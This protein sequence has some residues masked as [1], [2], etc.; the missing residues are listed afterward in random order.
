M[1]QKSI[2]ILAAV[3]IGAFVVNV[4]HAQKSSKMKMTTPIPESITTPAKIESR[5]GTLEF[6][7]GSP[8]QDTADKIYDY[9]DFMHGVEAFLYALP[10][11]SVHAAGRGI[12]SMGGDNQ[13][14]LI[15]EELMNARSLFLT[16][17]T[18]SIY[19]M[20]WLD[21]KD[22]P[23]VLETPPDVLG[24]V[25]DHWFR[26][27]GDIGNAGPDKGKGG[28]YLLL[29]PDY[30]GDVPQGYFV[31][32]SQTYQNLYF[33]RGFIKDGS[34][35]TAVANTKKFAKVYPLNAINN[36]PEMKYIDVSDKDFNTIGSNDYSFYTDIN[37]I[38]QAEPN[39]AYSPEIL[40]MLAA[41]GIE[42]GKT[43]APDDKLKK[44][45]TEAVAVGNAAARTIAFQ[46][47]MD[48]AYLSPGSSWFFTFVGG[49][50]QFLSQP[51]VRNLAAR[52]LF[53]YSY[54]GIT[55]AMAF[56]MVGLGSQYVMAT[57]DSKGM[58][59]DGSKTYKIQLPANVPA[60][61][62]WSLVA[63][64]SQTRSMLQTDQAFPSVGT[65]SK[66]IVTNAD[67]TIDI[68]F[69]PTA[70]KGHEKNW[71]QTIPGRGWAVLFRLYGPE[72]SWF[73][74]TWKPGE[75]IEVK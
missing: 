38:I 18:Q 16:A 57:T 5:I 49:S 27:V 31:L 51:G 33:W 45:L 26:Y 40:G 9:L 32:R 59:L 21:L 52:D 20:M 7:Q 15:M 56:K 44:T 23:L 8:T 67:G 62:F 60:K 53:H 42:K 36:Q 11:A 71:V 37:E 55:P 43:F 4:S 24:I 17:N 1:K 48:D 50:Y 34:T 54:T 46:P 68:W 28:K 14:V 39:E 2:H 70:P 64:D 35:A 74:K 72:E 65:A 73:N 75:F 66:G 3:L 10:G 61:D 25:N 47:R 22:G 41:I 12:K 63:Y 6:P 19:S 69:S 58:S 30:K 29:P 13:T